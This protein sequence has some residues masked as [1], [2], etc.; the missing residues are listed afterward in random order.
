MQRAIMSK[1]HRIR[2]F[3]EYATRKNISPKDWYKVD[4]KNLDEKA[5]QIVTKEFRGSL[6]RALCTT[7][8]EI[9]WHPWKF[10]HHA[11]PAGFW[12]NVSNQRKFLDELGKEVG[13]NQLD[14]WYSVMDVKFLYQHGG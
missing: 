1:H 12:Q 8:P 10:E 4:I 7:F 13:I 11:V 3:K 2:V 6:Y 14:D 5:A 9:D